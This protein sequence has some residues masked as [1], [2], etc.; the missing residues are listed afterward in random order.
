MTAGTRRRDAVGRSV[1]P[2][3]A[4][5]SIRSVAPLRCIGRLVPFEQIEPIVTIMSKRAYKILTQAVVPQPVSR[6]IEARHA[7]LRG[8]LMAAD[9]DL[10]GA[11]DLLSRP[12]V[13]IVGMAIWI[14]CRKQS[15]SPCT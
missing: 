9:A 6:Q 7:Q 14:D 5:L 12:M 8:D 10:T 2:V 4:R 3:P 11:R 15:T 13:T 1:T